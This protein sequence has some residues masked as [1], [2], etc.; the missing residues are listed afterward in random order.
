M[1]KTVLLPLG[2]V[3]KPK[4]LQPGWEKM[5]FMITGY[6]PIAKDT[7][8]CFDYTVTPWP[9]GYL[10]V[11]NRG[12]VAFCQCNDESIEEVEFFGCISE[13][14]EEYNRYLLEEAKKRRFTAPILHSDV[15]YAS[16]LTFA[17][18]FC[19][20]LDSSDDPFLPLGSIVSV[21]SEENRRMMV[22]RQALVIPSTGEAKD[23]A[24]LFWPQG[25]DPAV[26]GACLINR[27]VISSV[28]FRGYENALS[29]ELARRLE[30]KRKGS[31]FSRI[32]GR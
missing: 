4:R 19:S 18:S 23:Y 29:Q 5:R 30:K 26:S 15:S 2:T 10:N 11:K 31:L 1:R 32:L 6:F 22:Y 9:L 14:S 13:E 25:D 12:Q 16:G 3:F 24:V 7:G 8:E 27:S 28:H 17:D 21:S 20:E